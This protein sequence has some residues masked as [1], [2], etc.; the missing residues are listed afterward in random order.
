M[1]VFLLIALP[2]PLD[3]QLSILGYGHAKPLLHW[4][5]S[6]RVADEV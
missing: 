2:S 3:A 5:V 6:N 4:E 1:L